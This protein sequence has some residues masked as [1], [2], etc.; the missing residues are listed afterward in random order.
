[1]EEEK[2]SSIKIYKE[3]W[4][5]LDIDVSTNASFIKLG[6]EKIKNEDFVDNVYELEFTIDPNLLDDKKNIANI[7][8]KNGLNE[9]KL[10]IVINKNLEK[11]YQREARLFER[12]QWINYFKL[13]MEFELAMK[14]SKKMRYSLRCLQYLTDCL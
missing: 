3:N 5:L 1:M 11:E 13:R 6:K 8:F 10:E 2:T 12:K 7:N 9:K 14:N 4:G